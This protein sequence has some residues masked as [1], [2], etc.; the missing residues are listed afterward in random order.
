MSQHLH[1]QSCDHCIS[2]HV[3]G[4]MRSSMFDKS[5]T[6][7]IVLQCDMCEPSPESG[8]QFCPAGGDLDAWEN[9]LSRMFIR[10]MRVFISA[11]GV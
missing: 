7:P 11:H 9:T 1:C 2:A 10:N 5:A 4:Q 8:V 3:L 6:D